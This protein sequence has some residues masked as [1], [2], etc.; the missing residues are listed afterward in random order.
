MPIAE[1]FAERG[2]AEFRRSRRATSRV[3]LAERARG[4]RA[5][6]RRGDDARRRA[7]ALASTRSPCWSRSTSTPPGSACAAATGRSRRTRREFRRLYDERQPLYREVADAVATDADGVILAA[8]GVHHE[9]G[10]A[11]PARRARPGHRPGGARRRRHRD[12]HL[13]RA[14]RRGAR[15]PAR[16]DPRAAARRG[17]EA[18]ARRRAPLDASSG[19]TAAGRSSRSAAAAHRR[20]RVRRGDLPAR[21]P[22]GRRADDARRPGRRGDR[23]QDRRSTSRRARTS[24]A[25]ST[26]RRAS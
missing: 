17:G 8:G 6:R 7:T 19:S 9:L 23:R 4:D 11:R 14:R 21:R 26:G 15:R 1:F 12:G 24:S 20:R 22:V 18:A 10:R 5:R 13:R 3:A 16:L 25:P 2:E